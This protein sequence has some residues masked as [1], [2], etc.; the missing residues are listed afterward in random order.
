M[1]AIVL[2]FFILTV[3]TAWAA[4]E[5]INLAAPS[6]L[7]GVAVEMRSA[8]FWT[9]R[10]PSPDEPLLT[11]QGIVPLNRRMVEQGLVENLESS[12][13]VL[14]GLKVRAD[15]SE[16]IEGLKKRILFTSDGK[17]VNPEFV[18]GFD[19]EVDSIPDKVNVLFG[20]VV[21]PADQRLLPTTQPLYAEPGDVDFDELQNS[22][23]AL[24]TPLLVLA[25]SRDHKWFFTRGAVSSGWVSAGSVAL[26]PEVFFR[27]HVIPARPVVIINRSADLFLDK[28]MTEFLTTARM[29][30]AF[31]YKSV[32]PWFWVV[33][34]PAPDANGGVKFIPAYIPKKDASAGFLP[35]TPR[36]IYEQAFKL[37]DAPYGWGDMNG[38]QDCSRFI[39]MVFA[40]MGIQLPRNSAEQGKAGV[41]IERFNE[42]LSSAAK[43]ILL[44][45]QGV[46]GATILRLNGHI[47]LYLGAYHDK[48]Y[49]I[50]STWAYRESMPD[51]TQR[52]RMIGRVAVTP[53]SLGLGSAKG[54]LLE[55]II[56]A[57]V[58]K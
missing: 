1:R 3:S 20:F 7:A 33:E 51:G 58:L 28:E 38:G 50:H 23:L 13:A 53:L 4:E 18:A 41:M 52:A 8:G 46:P 34:V 26:V 47:V 55:R 45:T 21:A 14:P 43:E 11:P 27:K 6:V 42:K 44:V 56:S 32:S 16:I 2:V 40:A 57:R 10:H 5:K 54:S 35:Y 30:V 15:L 24:G 17:A 22:G 49:A 36:V 48:P 25:H 37:L 29:G 39:Q 19:R 9:G 31:A 12:P